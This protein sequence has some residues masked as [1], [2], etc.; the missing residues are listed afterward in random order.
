V[1]RKA[2]RKRGPIGLPAKPD[3]VIPPCGARDETVVAIC[4]MLGPLKPADHTLRPAG[5]GSHHHWY[6]KVKA[7]LTMSLR[8]HPEPGFSKRKGL[9]LALEPPESEQRNKIVA[10]PLIDFI[11]GMPMPS[12][13]LKRAERSIQT[14]RDQGELPP[15]TADALQELVD[16]I[17]AIEGRVSA[18]E[19][20]GHG[21]P[22]DA[23]ELP[24][25]K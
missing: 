17:R 5:N 8:R 16:V 14:I 1:P 11:R 12:R 6:G 3:A 4:V 22:A 15:E 9:E 18:P 19:G 20:K 25:Q 2:F 23:M 10:F 24:N 21:R 13:Q 7:S